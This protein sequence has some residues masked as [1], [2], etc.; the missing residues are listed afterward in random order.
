MWDAGIFAGATISPSPSWRQRSDRYSI[1]AGRNLPDKEFRYLRTVIVTAAIHQG[2]GSQ[3]RLAANRSPSPSGIGQESAPI[4]RLPASQRPVFLVNSR[5]SLVCAPHVAV[6]PPSPEVTGATCRVPSRGFSRAPEPAQLTYLCRFAV[7]AASNS[8]VA[9]LGPAFDLPCAY[10]LSTQSEGRR[11]LGRPH[12][13]TVGYGS[14][15]IN[16]VSIAYAT[17]PRLRSD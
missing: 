14:R 11:N 7:R 2:F 16:R 9:F 17:W 10:A 15:N 4:R 12:A 8:C 13:F 1:R 6:G 5:L 3:R